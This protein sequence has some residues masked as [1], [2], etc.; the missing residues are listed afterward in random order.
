MRYLRHLIELYKNED[1]VTRWV[2]TPGH[3]GYTAKIL[4]NG[5]IS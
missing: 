2:A 5:E 3:P 4:H 1:L